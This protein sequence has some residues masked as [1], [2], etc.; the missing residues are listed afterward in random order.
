MSA[1]TQTYIDT[2]AWRQKERQRQRGREWN[3]SHNPLQYTKHPDD[4]YL[5]HLKFCTRGVNRALCHW[6]SFMPNP[7]TLFLNCR[8]NFKQ[9]QVFTVQGSLFSFKP[10]IPQ[11]WVL[12]VSSKL[13]HILQKT[14]AEPKSHAICPSNQV[15][16]PRPADGLSRRA[17]G[18]STE[19]QEMTGPADLL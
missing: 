6:Y 18:S 19:Q 9:I 17:T 13:D 11:K 3:Y 12:L 10:E 1:D 14:G 8:E 16:A 4:W 5:Y 7:E 15:R 2:Y